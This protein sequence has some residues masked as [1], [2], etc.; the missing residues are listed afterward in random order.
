MKKLFVIFAAVMLLL[1][2]CGE[3]AEQNKQ[4][5]QNSPFTV[6][7]TRIGSRTAGDG[8]VYEVIY[9]TDGTQEIGVMDI[10]SGTIKPLNEETM[11]DNP[12][13]PYTDIF[14]A[15]G[16]LY[17]LLEY[18]HSQTIYQYTADG[19]FVAELRI[20]NDNE[21]WIDRYRTPVISDGEKLYFDGN[22]YHGDFNSNQGIISLDPQ[23]MTMSPVYEFTEGGFTIAGVY[24]DCFILNSTIAN[25]NPDIDQQSIPI[26]ELLNIKTLEREFLFENIYKDMY[27]NNAWMQL[28]A[29]RIY[30]SFDFDDVPVYN[31]TT[32]ER[33]TIP[34]HSEGDGYKY[35]LSMSEPADNRIV[36]WTTNDDFTKN[37][38]YVYDLNND[39]K[40]K[41]YEGTIPGKAYPSIVKFVDGYYL[42]KMGTETFTA[43]SGKEVT[44]E[45]YAW[46]KAKD[47]Y[48]GKA[49]F[50]YIKN[51]V[52][53]R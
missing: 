24:E 47:L 2:G 42:V 51:T 43:Q 34:L 22:I 28:D 36:V 19:K 4:N 46:I 45:L 53:Y 38:Y 14:Y 12:S 32:R 13:L 29:D 49:N 44:K 8:C 41:A 9:H 3:S 17:H 16:Y 48:D 18:S 25:T 5:K 35:G 10:K 30:T 6:I 33:T 20:D 1:C 31:I 52:E 26:V 11:R 15:D 37:S 39:T 27:V 50:E 21:Y 23:T 40:T 7:E